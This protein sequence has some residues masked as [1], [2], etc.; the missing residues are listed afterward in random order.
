MSKYQKFNILSSKKSCSSPTVEDA[1]SN[2]LIS[3]K[4]M[5][6]T[7]KTVDSYTNILKPFSSFCK[8]QGVK[9]LAEADNFFVDSP[10]GVHIAIRRNCSA[11]RANN[12]PFVFQSIPV[13]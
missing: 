6:C 12:S 10:I 9:K 8:L 3:K 4:A 5:N 11:R 7:P 1:V 13:P 2:F